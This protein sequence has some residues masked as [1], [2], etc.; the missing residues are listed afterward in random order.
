MIVESVEFA[1][2]AW[3]SHVVT[4]DLLLAANSTHILTFFAFNSL[5]L[6]A[7]EWKTLAQN[8]T[9]KGFA[10]IFSTFSPHTQNPTKKI[11]SAF[12]SCKFLCWSDEKKAKENFEG[13]NETKQTQRAHSKLLFFLFFSLSLNLTR[14]TLCWVRKSMDESKLKC[15]T[16]RARGDRPTNQLTVSEKVQ[17]AHLEC[18]QIE[19]S[20]TQEKMQNS[21]SVYHLTGERHTSA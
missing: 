21:L 8:S 19:I 6:Q 4:F 11:V 13:K 18:T 2:A 17:A 1:A 3:K 7:S 14:L 9:L 10:R 16:V 20:H 5:S 12:E 15:Q